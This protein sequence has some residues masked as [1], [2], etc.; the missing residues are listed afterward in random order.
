MKF[1]LSVLLTFPLFLSVETSFA[2]VAELHQSRNMNCEACHGKGAPG[3][4]N[5]SEESCI[6]CHSETPKGKPVNIEG[7]EMPNIHKGHFDTYECLQCHQ[8][9]KPSKM[10]CAECHKGASAVKVP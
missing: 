10:A 7:K 9:H 6:G 8:G 3:A 4:G 1:L 5:V 2:Q